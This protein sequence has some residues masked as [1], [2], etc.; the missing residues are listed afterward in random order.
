MVEN[1]FQKTCD[2]ISVPLKSKFRDITLYHALL[3]IT[4]IMILRICPQM[5]T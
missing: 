1:C 2:I 4:F 3:H 5:L